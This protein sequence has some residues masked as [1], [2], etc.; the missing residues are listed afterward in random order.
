MRSSGPPLARFPRWIVLRAAVL[1]SLIA[2]ACA[3]PPGPDEWLADVG[4]LDMNV[5][6]VVEALKVIFYLP[7]PGPCRILD[8]TRGNYRDG[9]LSCEDVVLFDAE[10]RGDFDRM[11]AAIERS[12]VAVERILRLDG[13]VHVR[14]P[15]SSWQYNWA[16]VYGPDPASPPQATLPEEQWTHIRGRWWFHR[17]HDD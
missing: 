6:P 1:A 2:A 12:G 5:L 16:Y 17:E 7:E 9:R 15:D 13:W 3:E 8:Y 10:A 11:T 14:V 4:R